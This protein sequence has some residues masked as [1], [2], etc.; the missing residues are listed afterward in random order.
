MFPAGRDK[1][2]RILELFSVS[3][4]QYILVQKET[5]LLLFSTCRFF[6]NVYETIVSRL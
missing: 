4:C 5:E 2:E 3:K 1:V 6:F